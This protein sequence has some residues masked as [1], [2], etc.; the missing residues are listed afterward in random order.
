[1]FSDPAAY[2]AW[3]LDRLRRGHKPSVALSQGLRTAD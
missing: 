3:V 2:E 1:M